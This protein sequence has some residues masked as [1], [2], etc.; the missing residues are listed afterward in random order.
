MRR[1]ATRGKGQPKPEDISVFGFVIQDGE[2]YTAICVSLGL[3]AQADTPDKA[4]KRV[5][6]LSQEHIDYVLKRY[7]QEWREHL[8]QP[9]PKEYIDQFQD[10]LEE[11]LGVLKQG[12][13]RLRRQ[14]SKKALQARLGQLLTTPRRT[15]AEEVSASYSP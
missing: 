9:L 7:G 11:I 10:G 15:F 3:F 12:K 2:I 6:K 13:K 8:I 4:I 5:I 14:A 1:A